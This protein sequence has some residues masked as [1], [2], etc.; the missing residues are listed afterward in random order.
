MSKIDPRLK[1][2]RETQ[3]DLGELE[4]LGRFAFEFAEVPA[5]KVTVIV[6]FSGSI[7]ELNDIGFE[8]RTVAGDVATGSIEM[9]NLEDLA[10][11]DSVVKIESSRPM[12]DELDLS[13][14]EI[15]ADLV[16]N[17]PPGYKGSG[18]IVGIIDS[19]VC[20]QNGCFQKPDGTSRIIAIWDQYH[21]P[22]GVETPPPGYTYGVEYNQADINTALASADP[23]SVVRHKDHDIFYGHGTHVTGIAAGNGSVA[24]D[25]DPALTYVGVAPEADIIVVAN[26]V[27]TEALGDSA[28]TL[29]AVKYIFD[30]AESLGKP[31]VINQSQGDNLGPHDGTS[32][33][34]VGIDNLLVGTG[35]AVVKSAGN[36]GD[37]DIHAQGTVTA[38][39]SENVQFVVPAD[40]SSP[41][42]LDIWYSGLDR[43]SITLTD[44]GGN[45]SSLVDPG[46]TVTLNLPNGNTAFIDSVLNDP[47]NN[48]NRI[49]IQLSKG[50]LAYIEEGTWA[51]T[52]NGITV[53]NGQF[54]AWIERGREIPRF[55]G[56]HLNNDRTISIPGTSEKVI[57]VGSY[58]TRG[59]NVGEISTFS[60]RGP[61]RDGRQKPEI[62]APGERIMSVK[63][64]G[65]GDDRYRSLSGTSMASPHVAGTVALMLQQDDS[66]THT[67]IKE[68]LIISARS[69]GFTGAT[70]NDTWGY[71]KLDVKG[72]FDCEPVPM[73][74]LTVNVVGSGTVSKDPNQTT[75]SGDVVQL[76][77]NPASG[78][79]FSGWGGD[80]A[81]STSP[82]SVTMNGDKA[83]IATFEREICIVAMVTVGSMLA[84]HV[85]FLRTYRDEIVLKSVFRNHFEGLLARYY[86]F[87]PYVVRKMDESTVY[88]KFVKYILAYPFVF[89][90]KRAVST[91]QAI[92]GVKSFGSGLSK[93]TNFTR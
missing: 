26:R 49:Y 91:A 35:K 14:P 11:L 27:T 30:K 92:R 82:S 61:T 12:T 75:Y 28:G 63:S 78:W 57:T 51:F 36:A 93:R 81:G 24:G 79:R 77:A 22:Q 40:D 17:G 19:G 4:A 76:T 69:D 84:P 1:F 18:V 34:E 5:P 21:R 53:V 42:T 70:Q 88:E 15:R 74:S 65:S 52:L 72:A 90:A 56:P 45:V 54:D 39:G 25:G 9:D 73:Y 67:K 8:T 60:S 58:I 20:W 83:V 86:Q 41:N 16:H 66:L 64:R 44:P 59:I 13:V 38:G 10:A 29:D 37:D 80:L 46:A 85:H 6:Q 48:D 87:T 43:F 2:L 31:V 47:G 89:L 32:L 3:E 68:C 55:I 7:D 62:T 23:F 50:N 33:L 71:G